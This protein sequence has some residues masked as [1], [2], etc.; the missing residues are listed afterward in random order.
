MKVRFAA[1]ITICLFT[2]GLSAQP[3]ETIYE[4]N[5]IASGFI[6]SIPLASDG[7]YPIGFSFTFF[8]NTYT[9]FYVSVNGL[10]TFTDP[11]GLFNN[12]ATIPTATTPNNY[13]APF[14]DNLSII[15]GG[16]IMYKTVGAEPTRKCIIQFKNMGFDPLFLTSVVRQESLFEGF[17]RSS[18]G[19]RGLMQ[20]MPA[21]AETIV[22]SLNYPPNYTPEDLYRP[23]VNVTLGADYLETNLNG[24]NGDIF[25]AL[26]AYNAGPGNAA[27]WQQ[28]ANGDPDLLVEVVRFAETRD[29]IR[30][31]YEIYSIY[32]GLY[33]P[34][35]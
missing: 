9:N 29:Y 16:N 7:P 10:V 33:S 28:L 6:Q 32:K 12:E 31:I 11:D 20:I 14:W 30:S 34:I 21:T 13:I 19:A 25:A 26:A 35:Q 2:L 23:M 5:L 17:V 1:F 3:P 27:I 18:V 24:L 22:Q 4:G 15:D 8:G